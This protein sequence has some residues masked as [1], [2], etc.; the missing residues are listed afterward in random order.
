[1]AYKHG[2]I[3]KRTNIVS[4]VYKPVSQYMDWYAQE[5]DAK[6]FKNININDVNIS[7]NTLKE[8]L[9]KAIYMAKEIEDEKIKTMRTFLKRVSAGNARFN[10]MVDAWTPKQIVYYAY[11]YN[12]SDLATFNRL[13]AEEKG[14]R[15]SF[16]FP[17]GVDGADVNILL[18]NKI[19]STV[20]FDKEKTFNFF[21]ERMMK[22][23]IAKAKGILFE[24]Y[25]K[26]F[27]IPTTYENTQEGQ[28]QKTIL[29]ESIGD[30]MGV[31]DFLYTGLEELIKGEDT[32]Y[33]RPHILMPVDIKFS[34]RKDMMLSLFKN[35]YASRLLIKLSGDLPSEF[36]GMDTFKRVFVEWLKQEASKALL[37]EADA[38]QPGLGAQKLKTSLTLAL[39]NSNSSV[40][41]ALTISMVLYKIVNN[42][43]EMLRGKS[44]SNEFPVFVQNPGM[45]GAARESRVISDI[46]FSSE[47]LD[48]L[49]ASLF[50]GE[51]VLNIAPVYGFKKGLGVQVGARQIRADSFGKAITS[52]G[53]DIPVR[54]GDSPLAIARH[55][56]AIQGVLNRVIFE[57][58]YGKIGG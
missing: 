33:E 26:S 25:I 45:Y 5:Y 31:V 43:T 15:L 40:T 56:A 9:K 11:R 18:D 8:V 3:Y 57:L 17:D 32:V 13:L 53:A 47:V 35:V 19:A 12:N 16:N 10:A 55:K 50:D 20:R 27:K 4:T 38:R 44:F 52:S 28:L 6:A 39:N 30:D 7:L 21:M 51:H 54:P 58:N 42:I 34:T 49:Y 22:G 37:D 23:E 2:Q 48:S 41:K 14:L 29:R 46:L 36:K 1:M 24:E